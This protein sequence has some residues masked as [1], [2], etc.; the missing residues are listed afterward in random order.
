MANNPYVNKVVYGGSTLIDLTADTVTAARML[1]GYTAHN[2]SGAVVTGAIQSQAAQT[3]TPGTQDQIIAA[4]KYL[5]GAQTI[6]G[7]VNLV[8]ENI[9][10]GVTIFGVTGTAEGGDEMPTGAIMTYAGLTAPDGW[11][12][13]DGTVYNI[14]DYPDLAQFFE[15]QYGDA[16]YFGGDGTTTFAVQDLQGEFPRFAGA[17]SRANQGS[18]ANVGVHQDGTWVSSGNIDTDS[19]NIG[20]AINNPIGSGPFPMQGEGDYNY[21]GNP[22]Q[23]YYHHFTGRYTGDN[24]TVVRQTVRP[25]NTSL[26]ACIKT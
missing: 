17:N 5:A 3:I 18:G 13:C 24:T 1:S 6:Q 25:T 15:D 4:G 12:V 9:K 23:S 26:L 2:A 8:A 20:F 22:F 21:I 7:D 11:L 16:N 10:K 14:A 19:G